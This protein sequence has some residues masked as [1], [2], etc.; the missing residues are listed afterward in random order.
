MRTNEY[1]ESV[2]GKPN[3]TKNGKPFFNANKPIEELAYLGE[4]SMH[5][6]NSVRD[7]YI[8]L[9]SFILKYAEC[10]EDEDFMNE[11]HSKRSWANCV[12]EMAHIRDNN[13]ESF[14]L[15]L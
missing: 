5:K 12:Y 15:D 8:T 3:S 7:A 6:I 14:Q 13:K 10:D 9:T 4:K 11:I 2:R 1:F